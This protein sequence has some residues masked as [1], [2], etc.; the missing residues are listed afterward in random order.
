MSK[1]WSNII[2]AFK[3]LFKKEPVVVPPTP[4]DPNPPDLG[5]YL[6]QKEVKAKLREQLAGKLSMT[7]SIYLPDERFYCPSLK[8]VEKVLADTLVDRMKYI[9][10]TN[11]C[12][13]FAWLLKAEFV[14]DAY[15]RGVRRAPHCLGVVHGLLSTPHAINFMITDDMVVRFCEP[16]TDA[17]FLPRE[18]DKNIWLLLS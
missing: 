15:R 5:V 11:D 10:G 12:D 18:T 17:V 7:V 6:T 16:Q 2:N 8:Y 4:P 3:R 13:D 9:E 14:K 1:I